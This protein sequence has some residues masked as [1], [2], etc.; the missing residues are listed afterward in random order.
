MLKWVQFIGPLFSVAPYRSIVL[1]NNV[2]GTG[3]GAPVMTSQ[4]R[5]AEASGPGCGALLLPS[6]SRLTPAVSQGP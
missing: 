1:E 2:G 4:L 5:V 3:N 6:P